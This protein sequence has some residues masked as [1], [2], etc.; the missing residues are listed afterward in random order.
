[1]KKNKND[2]WF[3]G[4]TCNN[5][6]WR[7]EL[8]PLLEEHNIPY[9][10]PVVEDWTPECQEIEEDE[11]NNKCGVHLYV[12]TEEMLGTYSIAEVIHSAHL[13][14][15]YGTSVNKVM[16]IVLYSKKWKKHD[17]KSFDAIMNLVKN[18]AGTNAIA[19]Y[20]N[21]MK[22]LMKFFLLVSDVEE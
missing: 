11:K 9:F 3:L 18:I 4:G 10:N 6:K 14:N 15:M 16:F 22:E 2:K 7:D 20:V 1:M 5:S 12:I 13:A 19:T 8:I 21:D 17:I